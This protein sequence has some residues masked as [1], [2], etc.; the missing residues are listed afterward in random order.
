MPI[1]RNIGVV[2]LA[3][4]FGA[5]VFFSVVVAPAA[6]SV[7]RGFQI[8]NASEVAGAIVNRSLSAINVSGFLLGLVLLLFVWLTRSDHDRAWF[9]LQLISLAV[10]SLMTGLGQWVIATRIRLLRA[11]ISVP[12]EQIAIDDPRRIAFGNLHRYSVMALAIAMIAGL[13]ATLLLAR[14]AQTN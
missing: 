2:A 14:N 9:W 13:I 8:A 12:M 11:A 3:A 6:F 4:W 5:A 7:L 10:V 1:L